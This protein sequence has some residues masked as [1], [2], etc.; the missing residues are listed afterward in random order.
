VIPRIV[1][2]FLLISLLLHLAA[3]FLADQLWQ[4]DWEG[5]RFRARLASPPRFETPP[6]WSTDQRPELPRTAMEY[7]P[8]ESEPGAANELEGLMATG[9]PAEL[10]MP[11]LGDIELPA[12]E[13]V[14]PDFPKFGGVAMPSPSGPVYVDSLESEA[15]ELVRMEDRARA[16]RERAI[17]IL[18]RH[19]KRDLTG[20]VNFTLVRMDGI[21]SDGAALDGLARYLRDYTHL[22]AQVRPRPTIYFRSEQLLKDPIHFLFSGSSMNDGV[23]P[24]KST[25]MSDKE[26]K[27]MGRYLREGGFLFVEPSYYDTLSTL[28]PGWLSEMIV[29]VHDALEGEGRY[30]EI[31]PSHPIYHSFYDF[32]GGFPGE[33]KRRM[34][35]VPPPAWYYAKG[36]KD[37]RGLWGVELNGELVAVF[38]DSNLHGY[39]P[40]RDEESSE[41][42][43]EG[44]GGSTQLMLQVGTNIVTYALTRS[45]GL[46]PTKLPPAWSN[47]RPVVEVEEEWVLPDVRDLIDDLGGSLA[48]VRAPLGERIDEEGGLRVG[49]DGDFDLDLNRGGSQGVIVRNLAAGKHLVKVEYGGK[50]RELEVGLRGDRVLTVTFGMNRLAFLKRLRLKVHREQVELEEWRRKFSDLK[51]E[52]RYYEGDHNWLEELSR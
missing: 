44:G 21:E 16:D 26:L 34:L 51:I 50:R 23:P 11:G 9:R 24:G 1:R 36:M 42:G 39:W 4:G 20:Y 14:G 30:F 41:E 43:Q 22:M 18:D 33:D 52:E 15:M 47:K 8:A 6:R 5:E 2:I 37:R 49:L 17:V 7:L 35:D 3:L 46:T 25:H 27:M 13:E 40:Q 45:S 12:E 19:S 10:E 48:L 32:D 31:P 38:N 29:H 28:K